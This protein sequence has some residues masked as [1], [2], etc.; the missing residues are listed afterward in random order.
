MLK[1]VAINKDH[2]VFLGGYFTIL[3][4]RVLS[5]LKKKKNLYLWK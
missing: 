3:Y 2:K 5:K 1:C 4:A